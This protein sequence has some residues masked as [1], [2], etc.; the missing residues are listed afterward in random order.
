MK[1]MKKRMV[2]ACL[3]A[4]ML[5]AAQ[6]VGAMDYQG[7]PSYMTG[8]YY[9]A[10]KEVKLTGDPRTDI[11][12][13]ALSQVGYQ[14]STYIKE[15]SGEIAGNVNFTEYGEWYD[16]QDQWC[17]MFISWC[18]ALAGVPEDVI[19]KHAYTPNGLYKFRNQWGRAYSRAKVE[20]GAYTPQPGDIIYF[21]SSGSK[22][23]TNHVGIVT[24]YRDGVVYTVEGN[25]TSPAI[26]SNG[27]CVARKSYPI[28]NQ[29]IVY[30]CNPD[31]GKSAQPVQNGVEQRSLQEKDASLRQAL[32]LLESGGGYDRLGRTVDGA[33]TLGC[34][35]WSGVQAKDLLAQIKAVD[36]AAFARLGTA[37][38]EDMLSRD[39]TDYAFTAEQ[40]VCLQEILGSAAGVQVQKRMAEESMTAGQRLAESLGVTQAEAKLACG[41][42]YSLGGAMAVR[43]AVT[44]TG[45]EQSLEG[46]CGAMEVL[47]YAGSVILD[48]LS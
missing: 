13:I 17:A 24:G 20:A 44:L 42:L 34:G 16:M 23:T 28:T 38:L 14:E 11:V 46:I 9:R 31:Y 8:K 48:A 22:A 47:G 7:S 37:G 21:K 4:A 30:I 5:F 29:Y 36:P 43:R 32:N 27:G 18:A 3:A 39:W 40:E 10:L 6:P 35:Q 1:R 12:S 41:A 25:T 26:F 33:L 45:G 2:S 15:L 19:P